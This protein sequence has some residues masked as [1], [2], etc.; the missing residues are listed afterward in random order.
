[1]H[2][3]RFFGRKEQSLCFSLAQRNETKENIGCKL[4]AINSA[5]RLA[6]PSNNLWE[7]NSPRQV[8][9]QT[10]IPHYLQLII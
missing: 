1:M 3:F 9:A 7:L 2:F 4:F 10:V 8:G 5:L 6:K